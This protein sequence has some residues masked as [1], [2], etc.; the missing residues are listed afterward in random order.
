MRR[1]SAARR[2]FRDVSKSA[3]HRTHNDATIIHKGSLL[4]SLEKGV[5]NNLSLT[6]R[7]CKNN[8]L[9]ARLQQAG[10]NVLSTIGLT[11]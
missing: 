11:E 1:P 4:L 2:N 7:P 9:H 3:L 10:M 6:K 5:T 8:L